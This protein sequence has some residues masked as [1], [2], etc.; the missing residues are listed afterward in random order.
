MITPHSKITFH[1]LK[2]SLKPNLKG[3]FS[4]TRWDTDSTIIVTE[5]VVNIVKILTDG[6]TIH[7]AAKK[8]NTSTDGVISIVNAL[9][10]VGFIK[11]IDGK[12]VSDTQ[13]HIHP[14]LNSVPR[15]WFAWT[16]S[17]P[18]IYILFAFIVSGLGVGLYTQGYFPTYRNYFWTSDIFMVI[19]SLQ[20]LGFLLLLSHELGHFIVTK[21]IGG[22]AIMR[23]SHRYIYFIAETE[24]Y[25]IAEVPKEMRYLVYFAGMFVDFL[26]I[27]LCYWLMLAADTHFIELGTLRSIL[28]AVILLN[29]QGIVW[30]YNAFLRTDM[31]NFLSDF[32]DHENLHAN[33]VRF[34]A[35][36][37]QSVEK[38]LHIQ[39]PRFI[40]NA[41]LENAEIK[42][43][44]DLRILR[45][46]EKK[47]IS[48]YSF[49]LI[50][51]IIFIS[52]QFIF[53]ILPREF[54]FVGYATEGLIKA[55][56]NADTVN[57][58]KSLFVISMMIYQYFFVLFLVHKSKHTN[59]KQ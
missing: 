4:I 24:S 58:F 51:G 35:R 57:A 14:W 29:I 53:F 52:I 19:I 20:L 23:F 6:L 12:K 45:K 36:R 22:E 1:H 31:Y 40:R 7:D 25:H 17:K 30:Q 37:L 16:I 2:A 28:P 54:T 59:G 33:T 43:S 5:D 18:V 8:L 32:L 3:D 55:L 34:I 9:R 15:N 48:I 21:A 39:F 47:Q 27:A 41:V 49:I 11:S 56:Q 42:E 13:V 38:S 50:T 44:D 46:G 10:T 26:V